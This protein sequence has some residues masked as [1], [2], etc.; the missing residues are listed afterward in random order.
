MSEPNNYFVNPVK[1]RIAA[2]GAA[3]GIIVLIAKS[4]G[5]AGAARA[6]DHDFLYVDM[7][8][9]RFDAGVASEIAQEATAA[10]IAPIA[11]VRSF[12]DPDI[13]LLLDCGYMGIVVP[14]VDSAEAAR[15]V[16]RTVKFPPVGGRSVGGALA[17]LQSRGVTLADFMAGSNRRTLLLCMIESREGVAAMEEIC[18]V[19]GVDGLYMGTTDLTA[20]LGKPGQHDDPEVVEALRRLVEVTSAH[21]KIAGAGGFRTREQTIAAVRSGVRFVNTGSDLSYILSGAAQNAESFR[22]AI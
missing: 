9:A 14:D 22:S 8:H 21:G 3:L 1:A 10:G 12:R 2:G 16:V 7:Q 18:A 4:A 19:D 20:N 6:S 11:R 17:S 5:I 13:S 15:E